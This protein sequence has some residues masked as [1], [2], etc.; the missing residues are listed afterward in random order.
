LVILGLLGSVATRAAADPILI[1]LATVAPEGTAWARILNT[2]AR[3]TESETGG[4]VKVKWYYGGIAGDEFQMADR[5]RRGQLDGAASGG[6]LCERLAPSLRVLRVLG[7]ASHH[8]EV[9]HVLGAL[10]STMEEELAK[11]GLAFLV[12]TPLGPH[13]LFSR[14]PV[15]SL[16]DLRHGNFWVWDQD[17]VMLKE[18]REFGVHV[19]PLPLDQ[20]AHAYEEGRI[21]GF[22]TP[23][24]VALGF[25]WSA[26]ARY[27]TDLRLDM[28]SACFVIADRA[29]D[30]I[31]VDAR[32]VV[33]AA[34]AKVG[35]RIE[36]L[37]ASQDAQL[38]GGLF[39]KQGLQTIPVS[40]TFSSE[41]YSLAQTVRERLDEKLVSRP[42]L[43][44][45][46]S[47]LA[48][49]RASNPAH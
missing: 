43:Q 8:Q 26:Q 14:T 49:Y 30:T 28:I 15:R 24:S 40:Q 4:R 13:I 47:I 36:D 29:F 48:D 35:A 19:V 6:P 42:L 11:G 16:G 18:L 32:K 1:R 44:R 21:D 10:H 38:L 45:V 37:G 20:A 22:L 33:R 27:V 5:I 3:E 2:F 46:L 34:A 39:A 12:A 9:A 7:L 23:A 25:Q 17:D 31:P 41:F